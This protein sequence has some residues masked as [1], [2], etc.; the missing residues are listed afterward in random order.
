[1][2]CKLFVGVTFFAVGQLSSALAIA[3]MG[4]SDIARRKV[5]C[6]ILCQGSALH[7]KHMATL[8]GSSR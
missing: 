4:K 5:L 7:G 8:R 3:V 2:P 6:Y 1:M